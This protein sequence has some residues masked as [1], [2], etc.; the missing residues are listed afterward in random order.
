MT[1]VTIGFPV[2]NGARTM[3]RTVDALLAQTYADFILLASDNASTD[4]TPDILA[5]YARRDSRVQIIRQAT[6]IGASANFWGLLEAARTPRF[7]WFAADDIAQPEYIARCVA[8]LDA[9]PSAILCCTD[10]IFVLPSGERWKYIENLDTVGC[11]LDRRLHRLL[12]RHGWYATYGI[13]WRERIL[14]CGVAGNRYGADVTQLAEWLCDWDITCVHEPLLHFLFVPKDA[15][16]YAAASGNMAP[17]PTQPFS[18]MLGDIGSAV[19]GRVHDAILRDRL[20][21]GMARTLAFE[22]RSLCETVLRE[23]NLRLDMLDVAQRFAIFHRLF[24]GG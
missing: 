7:G 9:A 22:N 19:R 5:H 14:Q 2:Y 16:A 13:G 12:N 1:Q 23:Q 11:D 10:V 8:R 20:V 24:A 3:E 17:V 18:Q 6:N 4:A 21:R 15:A